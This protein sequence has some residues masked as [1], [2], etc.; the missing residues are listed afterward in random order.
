[1]RVKKAERALQ[2]FYFKKKEMRNFQKIYNKTSPAVVVM[3]I[4]R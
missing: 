1:M 2:L 3:K 4:A